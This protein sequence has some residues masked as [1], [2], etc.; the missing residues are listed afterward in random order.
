MSARSR[1]IATVL[2]ARMAR[3]L[4][5]SRLGLAS[6]ARRRESF[7]RELRL[8]F[9]DLGPAFV[10]VGQLISVRPDVFSPEL[11]FEM[12]KLLDAVPPAPFEAVRDVI[13]RGLGHSPEEL[14]D[15]F[16][17]EPLASASI[18]QVHRAKLKES[19][20]PV[21]GPGLPAG[22]SVVVKVVRPNAE[23]LILSDLRVAERLIERWV[24]R[25]VLRSI[26][27]AALLAE[28]ARSLHRELDLRNEARV[29]DRFGF[30]FRDD[31]MVVAPRAVWRLTSRRVLTMEQVEGWRLTEMDDAR[32]AGVDAHALAVHGAE[33]YMRQVLELG[34]YHADLHPAN[35]F[36]TPEGRIAYLD[37]GI[38]GTLNLE[39]RFAVA[40]VLAA[41]TYGDAERALKYSAR[42]GLVVPE[43]VEPA[44]RAD[45][46]SLLAET[47][48]GG[49]RSDVKAFA[50]GFLSLL[51]RHG[52]PLPVG[53]GL[54]IKS[55]VT[56]E[57]VSRALCP[58]IDIAVAARPFATRCVARSTMT[59][60]GLAERVP[61]AMRAAL[62]EIV[63]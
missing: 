50:L 20:R 42:L 37:F 52:V 2:G 28:F 7:A 9:E 16:D 11:V 53:Y 21:W 19:A 5:R 26:D 10:K 58:D 43:G 31:S 39:E 24:P 56:V 27:L 61:A 4:V 62:R 3:A 18:A 33:V 38:V 59:P 17:R 35:L 12:E 55:L 46:A 57:G 47:M 32:R 63:G 13:L 60:E 54:L 34:R 48:G 25:R 36:L 6:P 23:R 45:V 14:F 22:S 1:R 30:D 49:R 44:L 8:A 41:T 51:R 15:A 29:A 40:Q